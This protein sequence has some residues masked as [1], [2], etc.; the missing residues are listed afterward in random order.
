MQGY[1]KKL[2]VVKTHGILRRIFTIQYYWLF[3]CLLLTVPYRIHFARHC[4]ELHITLAKETSTELK[5]SPG[6]S[7]ADNSWLSSTRNWFN[8]MMPFSTGQSTTVDGDSR[9][10]D[11]E[12]LPEVCEVEKEENRNMIDSNVQNKTETISITL[13]KTED[14]SNDLCG[15]RNVLN[16]EANQTRVSK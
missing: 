13:N 3:T 5:T 10:Q 4:D 8:G 2:L 16:S 6:L 12:G 11:H 1:K 9:V 7:P 15:G 14:G